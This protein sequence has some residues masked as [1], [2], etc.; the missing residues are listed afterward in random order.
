MRARQSP[1]S[2]NGLVKGEAKNFLFVI[3]AQENSTDPQPLV[4]E[5]SN[6]LTQ[7]E[8]ASGI[9]PAQPAGGTAVPDGEPTPVAERPPP[10]NELGIGPL[11]P[12]SGPSPSPAAEDTQRQPSTLTAQPTSS[13]APGQPFTTGLATGSE[14]LPIPASAGPGYLGVSP[15]R[16]GLPGAPVHSTLEP[17]SVSHLALNPPS[18]QRPVHF[19]SPFDPAVVTTSPPAHRLGGLEGI[20]RSIPSNRVLEASDSPTDHRSRVHSE[21]PQPRA[22]S[23]GRW[24]TVPTHA[25]EGQPTP[26]EEIYQVIPGVLPVIPAEEARRLAWAIHGSPRANRSGLLESARDTGQRTFAW[27]EV[28]ELPAPFAITG[29]LDGLFGE[30]VA[31]PHASRH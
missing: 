25:G 24:P 8:N 15:L 5:M 13:R 6:M 4:T 14:F 26:V 11:P 28:P 22:G 27:V 9:R 7:E 23:Q 1:T 18:Q 31:M 19:A 3:M 12:V 10:T 17:P 20:T 2:G 16:N 30:Y 29:S 21:F